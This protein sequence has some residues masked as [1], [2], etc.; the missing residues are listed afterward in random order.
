MAPEHV[1]DVERRRVEA[2]RDR[3]HLRG[4]GEEEH[5]IRIDEA[6]DE[7]GAGDPIDLWPGSGHSD[8]AP[9]FIARRESFGLDQESAGVPPGFEA[10]F[11]RPPRYSRT[12]S[13]ARAHAP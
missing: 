13:V 12:S 9:G 11:E 10:A 1:V 6:A 5:G 8:G 7:P 4:R 3:G 2:L